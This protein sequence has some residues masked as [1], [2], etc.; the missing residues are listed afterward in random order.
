[1]AQLN[2]VNVVSG[3]VIEYEGVRYEKTA[4]EARE[5]DIVRNMCDY[6]AYLTEG[7]Y[8]RAFE[9]VDGDP[10]IADDDDDELLIDDD[11]VVF[12]RISTPQSIADLLAAKRTELDKLNAE[13][14][15]LTDEVASLEV[16]LE[17]E[18]RPQVGDYAITLTGD[19]DIDEG[20]VVTIIEVEP[21]SYGGA[22]PYKVR[23]IIGGGYVWTGACEK[24]TPAEA[25]AALIAQVEALFS[26]SE[27]AA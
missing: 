15:A 18:K 23:P 12:R 1:M 22:Y 26:G 14:V 8:Y 27:E 24:L 17:T 7:A 2:G 3:G 10:C 4:D 5:G 16:V 13:I 11:F 9:D 6:T 19:D 25:R 20:V 21:P